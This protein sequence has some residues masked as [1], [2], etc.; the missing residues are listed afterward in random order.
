MQVKNV[1]RGIV[2]LCVSQLCRAPVAL[3]L[4]LGDVDAQQLLKQVLEAVAVSE[5][6]NHLRR[7]FRAIDWRG[8]C[9]VRVEQCRDIKPP[10]VKELEHVRVFEHRDQIGRFGLTHFDLNEVTIAIAP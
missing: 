4:V 3:L 10:K 8:C 1:R 5:G 2:Q 9:A 7:D 6:S